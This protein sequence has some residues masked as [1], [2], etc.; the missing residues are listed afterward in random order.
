MDEA[1]AKEKSSV[2]DCKPMVKS[3]SDGDTAVSGDD[4]KTK[5]A[6]TGV[7]KVSFKECA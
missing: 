2:E 3:S 7:K 6:L 4:A 5:D 1:K